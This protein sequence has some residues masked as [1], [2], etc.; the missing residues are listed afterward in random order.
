MF[1]YILRNRIS[2]PMNNHNKDI[3]N[4][5]Y[6]LCKVSLF[7]GI[8]SCLTLWPSVNGILQ[9]RILEWVAIPFSKGSSQPSYPVLQEDFFYHL[10]HQGSP[11]SILSHFKISCSSWKKCHLPEILLRICLSRI[12]LKWLASKTVGGCRWEEI[13]KYNTCFL[14]KE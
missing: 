13:E 4:S 2:A 8:Q 5:S 11:P 6:R 9:A 3:D 14:H 1:Y 10:T 12:I 7:E